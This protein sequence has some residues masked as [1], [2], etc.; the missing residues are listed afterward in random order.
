MLPATRLPPPVPST[1]PLPLKFWMTRPRKVLPLAASWT[2]PFAP[3][4]ASEPSMTTWPWLCV[5]PSMTTPSWIDGSCDAGWITGGVIPPPAPMLK[6]TVSTPAL[7][8]AWMSA[9]RSVQVFPSHCV[10]SAVLLTT[11][12]AAYATRGGRNANNIAVVTTAVM[13]MRPRCPR[14]TLSPSPVC[15]PV[16]PTTD[17]TPAEQTGL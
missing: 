9:P 8:P 16:V 10:V 17:G 15:L 14:P 2:R 11:Y 12:V 1:I 5:V 3:A 4:P 6:V 7:R 13:N